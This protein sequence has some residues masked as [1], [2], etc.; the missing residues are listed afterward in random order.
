MYPIAKLEQVFDN[1]RK[2][3]HRNDGLVFTKENASYFTGICESMLKWKAPTDA[4]IDFRIRLDHN[5]ILL[6]FATENGEDV[7][8]IYNPQIDDNF[9]GFAHNALQ[10]GNIVEFTYDLDTKN[11]KFMRWR[12]DKSVPNFKSV[13]ESVWNTITNGVTKQELSTTLM[14][15]KI[16][17][18]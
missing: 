8:D 2:Q 15:Q 5:T 17:C 14:S 18:E 12:E 4:S 7:Y 3:S 10:D 6:L 9:P 16:Q 1:I 13:V 11:W